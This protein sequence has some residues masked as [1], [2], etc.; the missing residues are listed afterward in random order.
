MS[1]NSKLPQLAEEPTTDFTTAD[2][3]KINQYMTDG[4]PGVMAVDDVKMM[5]IMD[6]YLSGKTYRQISTI[7]RIP[8]VLIMYL[9]HR[10]KW[11]DTRKEYLEDLD[12][13]IR[14]RLIEAKI[15]N[16]D[17]LLQLMHL[18]QKKI[19]TK[20]NEYLASGDEQYA[21]QIDLKEVDKYLKT[22]EMLHRMT[23]DPKGEGKSLIGLNVGDG[24]TITRTGDNEI[25][26]TPKKKAIGE[27]LTELADFKRDQENKNKNIGYDI[28]TVKGENDEKN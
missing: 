23:T 3:E 28:T 25:E 14:G 8:K 12:K 6:M 19:G 15:I 4:L 20:I 1:E 5:R 18:W 27:M 22:A 13:S 26:I 2:L 17:F 10:F 21:N 11:F 7:T 9:S 24:A 16:Q